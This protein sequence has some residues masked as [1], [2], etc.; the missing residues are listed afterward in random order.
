[1]KKI[2]T[3]LFILSLT[4]TL[5]AQ[6]THSVSVSSN[7][8][9][10]SSLTIEVGDIVEWTNMGGVHNANGS[11]ATFPSNPEGFNSGPASGT[12]WTYS[13]TF[14]T[15]GD[16]DYQCDPHVTL[17][18]V[19]TITVNDVQTT[20][21]NDLI[22]DAS[23]IVVDGDAVTV[24]NTDA[25][26]SGDSASCWDSYDTGDIWLSFEFTP[27]DELNA[28]EITTAAGTSSDSQLAL[29]S[30][31]GCPDG[32][33]VLTQLNC[34]EDIGGDDYMSYIPPTALEAG[35]YYIQCGTWGTPV[36]SFDV[37]VNSVQAA[38]VE[39]E[40]FEGEMF[41]PEC[42]TSID[43]DGDGYDWFQYGSNAYA[44][45]LSAGSI[46]FIEG[47][48]PLTPDNYLVSPHLVL[49]N[50]EVFSFHV[51]ADDPDYMEDVYGVFISTSG[52][53]EADFTTELFV[54]TLATTDW[55]EQ[56]I[57]L[58]AYNGMSVYIAFRH[59]NVTDEY[60]VKIDNVILPGT[61]VDCI[62]AV[63]EIEK[64]DFSIYPNPNNGQFNIIN[65][66][67]DGTY[68]IEVIDATGRVVHNEQMQINSNDQT[69]INTKD[70]KSGI[71][72]VKM[73]N[74]N[75]NYYRTLRMIIK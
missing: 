64:A 40:S 68:I 56:I 53:E 65:E 4:F 16:Y 36:G 52:N 72:F 48:G 69:T 29:Y 57:D 49:G 7:V 74:M 3:L 37:E 20:P 34:N 47:V 54:D 18:M 31:T 41:V 59:Y 71:Y 10:P 50:D 67:N 38:V 75:E 51:A 13:F 66:G 39:G 27:T 6:T 8:F 43:A 12:A 28:I 45:Y 9:T 26:F 23:T 63:K 24:D 60:I 44:G 5:Q 14:N 73:T 32:P 30:A 55:E 58:S 19:G 1:M 25:T 21:V 61:V 42:W 33:V 35:T 62:L 46:S 15:V 70:L 2:F 11:T 22:C 17:G